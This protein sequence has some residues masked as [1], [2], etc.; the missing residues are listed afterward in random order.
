[1]L[2]PYCHFVKQFRQSQTGRYKFNVKFNLQLLQQQVVRRDL[3]AHELD[4]VA[5][6]RVQRHRHVVGQV[7]R[8]SFSCKGIQNKVSNSG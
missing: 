3:L 2:L 7:V 1:M 5:H 4:D 6:V 8:D